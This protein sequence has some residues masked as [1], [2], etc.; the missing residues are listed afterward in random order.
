ME[1]SYSAALE[2]IVHATRHT[3]DQEN[4]D[5]TEQ[6]RASLVERINLVKAMFEEELRNPEL[7][8]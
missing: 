1:T 8:I 5:V 6:E 4:V 2:V 7:I 3:F